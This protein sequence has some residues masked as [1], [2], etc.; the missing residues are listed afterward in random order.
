MRGLQFIMFV[1]IIPTEST[2]YTSLSDMKMS[3]L[4]LLDYTIWFGKTNIRT[5]DQVQIA[6]A[7]YR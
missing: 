7:L 5:L 2:V 6:A 4:L 1:F 3:P